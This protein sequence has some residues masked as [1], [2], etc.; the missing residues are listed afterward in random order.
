MVDKTKNK[1]RQ[2]RNTK[3]IHGMEISAHQN[4]DGALRIRVTGQ[5]PNER[6]VLVSDIIHQ[7]NE[8]LGSNSV[9]SSECTANT[10]DVLQ[11]HNRDEKIPPLTLQMLQGAVT[12]VVTGAQIDLPSIPAR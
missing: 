9:Y 8:E 1:P 3:L 7:I 12:K 6:S 5:T 10:Y 2:F 11:K 4:K